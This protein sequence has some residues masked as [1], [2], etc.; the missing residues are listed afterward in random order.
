LHEI[1]IDDRLSAGA[2]TGF[3]PFTRA[4]TDDIIDVELFK[5]C[6]DVNLIETSIKVDVSDRDVFMCRFE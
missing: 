2:E 5:F 1:L 4:C 3:H 6:N